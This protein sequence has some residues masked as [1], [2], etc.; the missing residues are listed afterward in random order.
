MGF[1]DI[2]HAHPERMPSSASTK[3]SG[4]ETW[5]VGVQCLAKSCRRAVSQIARTA[6]CFSRRSTEM[7]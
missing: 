1:Y 6:G 2:G 4:P 5:K 3:S 7:A